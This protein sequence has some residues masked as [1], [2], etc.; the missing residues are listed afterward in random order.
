M[1]DLRNRF[2]KCGQGVRIESGAHVEHPEQYSVGDR[3]VIGPNFVSLG[4]ARVTLGDDC[5]V[6]ANSFVQGSGHLMIGENVTCYP[7]TY[8]SVGDV[9]GS[10]AIGQHSHFA[11][12][13]ALY[14]QGGLMLGE[15]CNV[16]A[17][18][19]LATVQH[20]STRFPTTPMGRTG[21]AEPITIDD[22]VWIGAN[23]TVVP[24]VHIATGCIVGA[25]AVVTHDTEPNGLYLG[26]PATRHSDRKQAP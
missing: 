3:V 18:V 20:N 1:Q 12:G 25:G 23:A 26:V 21:V 17:H 19:V 4:S 15:W 5:V 11:P 8:I 16:A 13:C 14:G 22:D 10:I 24:G 2:A 7:N 6:H 9:T